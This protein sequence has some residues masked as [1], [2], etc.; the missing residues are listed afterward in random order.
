MSKITIFAENLARRSFTLKL[1]GLSVLLF[2]R[3]RKDVIEE[4]GALDV[5]LRPYT[6]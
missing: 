3:A 1:I 4:T 5:C 6:Y 2:S